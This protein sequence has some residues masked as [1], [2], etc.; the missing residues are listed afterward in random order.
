VCL[1]QGI[2]RAPLLWL[3]LLTMTGHTP[4][5]DAPDQRRRFHGN[6]ALYGDSAMQQLAAARFCVIGMG[7]VGSWA[8]EALA[9]SGAGS[10]TLIDMDHIA[11][12][13]INRQVHAL[14][15]TL[16]AAKVGT[17]AARIGDINPACR[18]ETIDDWISADKLQNQLGA[19][20]DY[21]LDCI[22]NFRTK[23]A[24][25]AWCRRNKQPLI[26][27]G[28]AGGRRDPT[29]IRVK[30][31]SRSENDPLL[32]RTR[33]LLRQDYNFPQNL[34]RRFHIPC[35]Y[36]DEQ[37]AGH[38]GG[39]SGARGGTSGALSCAGGMGSS[40]MVTASMGLIAAAQSVDRYLRRVMR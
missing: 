5:S 20:F 8:A 13:N 11:V 23:A 37:V 15:S 31:L 12:S 28:G 18:V 33:R 27:V 19:G 16:G 4:Q 40:M 36:S 22:D 6:A 39:A 26:T 1:R 32:S 30:D 29:H 38:G 35:V 25:V 24:L 17:M 7:G 2:T 3:R 21:V 14:E 34:R 10:I 9:R